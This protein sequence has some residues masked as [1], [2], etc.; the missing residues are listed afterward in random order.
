MHTSIVQ[1]V[2]RGDVPMGLVN[3]YYNYRAQAEDP[4]VLSQNYFFPDGDI[5]SLL[6]VTA[7]GVISTTDSPEDAE[8]FIKF[9]LGASA[10]QF[11]S[12]ETLEYP[13]AAEV[14]PASELPS[15]SSVD[16]ATYDFD[17]LG[18]GLERT[19]ELIDESGLESS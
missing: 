11:F 17:Q 10:Q 19:K 18:G 9:M 15:L 16:V 2:G 6:I 13:L 14:E 4:G 3:H 5:G 1:A 7:V 8:R 12:R